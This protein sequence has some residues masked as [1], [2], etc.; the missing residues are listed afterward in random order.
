M[1]RGSPTPAREAKR[2]EQMADRAALLMKN[3]DL[4]GAEDWARQA[5]LADPD[6]IHGYLLLGEILER[7]ERLYEA[8]GEYSVALLKAPRNREPFERLFAVFL[9]QEKFAEA[10]RALER[11][12]PLLG[13]FASA[14]LGGILE[15]RMGRQDAALR[16]YTRAAWRVRS[17]ATLLPYLD[18]HL[19]LASL[20]ARMGRADRA[21]LTILE[22]R[23]WTQARKAEGASWLLTHLRAPASSLEA[24]EAEYRFLAGVQALTKAMDA[25]GAKDQEVAK[26]LTDLEIATR[27]KRA[28][29]NPGAVPDQG[30]L[31]AWLRGRYAER[32]STGIARAISGLESNLIYAPAHAA[33]W[34]LLARLQIMDRK[35]LAA[36]STLESGERQFPGD[37]EMLQ[38]RAGLA[39]KTGN[40]LAQRA[41]LERLV[42]RQRLLSTDASASG[43]EDRAS[44]G[45]RLQ[46]ADHYFRF[47]L[48][49]KAT[50]LLSDE[51]RE[52]FPSLSALRDLQFAFQG[53]S[54]APIED[55]VTY[56]VS[57]RKKD[58]ALVAWGLAR[59]YRGAQRLGEA[60]RFLSD[61][62]EALWAAS[63]PPPFILMESATCLDRAEQLGQATSP[64]VARLKAIVSARYGSMTKCMLIA[65]VRSGEVT[66][67]ASVEAKA[68]EG[69]LKAMVRLAWITGDPEAVANLPLITA[70]LLETGD[71]LT[72]L[73][74]HLYPRSV[75]C[76]ATLDQG[77]LIRAQ[78][79]MDELR[80]E[81]SDHASQVESNA[82]RLDFAL[83]EERFDLRRAM[84]LAVGGKRTGDW[85][86]I[87]SLRG[88][89]AG[90]P[91]FH[92]AL[93]DELLARERPGQALRVA[94]AAAR[95]F[96]ESSGLF[97]QLAR[98]Q[99]GMES[100]AAGLSAIRWAL[101]LQPE[102]ASYY[103]LEARLLA[104]QKRFPEAVASLKKGLRRCGAD[105]RLRQ[106]EGEVAFAM[107]DFLAALDRFK[108]LTQEA[109]GSVETWQN[110]GLS[111]LYAGK[112]E[113]AAFFFQRALLLFP[114]S[115]ASRYHLARARLRLGDWKAAREELEAYLLAVPGDPWALC[116]LGH[117]LERGLPRAEPADFKVITRTART[118]YTA[119]MEGSRYYSV[120]YR[121]AASRVSA[122]SNFD[123]VRRRE[124][125]G[126][127]VRGEGLITGV[128]GDG[129]V[130]ALENGR[131]ESWDLRR[132][133]R[134]WSTALD[135]PALFSPV[136][137][138]PY[139]TVATTTG[140]IY[141]MTE[142]GV[143]KGLVRLKSKP[144]FPPAFQN[145]FFLFPC[146]QGTIEVMQDRQTL[147]ALT[148]AADLSTPPVLDGTRVWVGLSNGTLVCADLF[149]R[150]ILRMVKLG[151]NPGGHLRVKENTVYVGCDDHRYYAI[152]TRTGTIDYAYLNESPATAFQ[153]PYGYQMLYGTLDGRAR[154]VDAVGRFYWEWTADGSF[155]AAPWA[156]NE[157]ALFPLETGAVSAAGVAD[158]KW[159]W[160]ARLDSP[161]AASPVYVDNDLMAVCTRRGYLYQI[162]LNDE[163][164]VPGLRT[165]TRFETRDAPK[166]E[167]PP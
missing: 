18:A 32:F 59:L 25:P 163:N 63:E 41:A 141:F 149:S 166:T 80:R 4:E 17:G 26:N 135:A 118:Y 9:S 148:F 82:F 44:R 113:E 120:P 140:R 14:L 74:W 88:R 61:G 137:N 103:A 55:R 126:A 116:A 43:A 6:G 76:L 53:L 58:P 129:L 151:G 146:E 10:R 51:E 155:S 15:E 37:L 64:E 125:L 5:L 67:V 69:S 1:W 147:G 49:E 96:P 117:V 68:D 87:A 92:E 107:G 72:H 99:L 156:D 121:W 138:G 95:S 52:S 143:L 19:A 142:D 46:L 128:H 145:P 78:T 130:V 110:A 38:L 75:L 91:W 101:R 136:A 21:V 123:F 106:A 48:Y 144:A 30:I 133:Q 11:A 20:Q 164:G 62:F 157:V 84:S 131:I 160:T 97:Y 119:A 98:C 34:R 2:G 65:R 132:F 122:L 161:P 24:R 102:E 50:Q 42:A 127:P 79:I 23:Q 57:I 139:L 13:S 154:L 150:K 104:R 7:Q 47:G 93:A 12:E 152:D 22:A 153:R 71:R 112:N 114:D 28:G 39:L 105:L 35:D 85:E 86:K 167:A 60:S 31:L 124:A 165:G 73:A 40:P 94:Q 111:A 70:R 158:G 108:T 27:A 54:A 159:R 115:E 100:P 89:A 8:E 3:G 134:K 90:S 36:W 77:D 56:L 45:A 162:Y 29:T 109:P 33:S 81:R 16:A 83:L 66:E